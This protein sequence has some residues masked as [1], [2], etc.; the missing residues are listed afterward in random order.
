MRVSGRKECQAKKGA[1]TGTGTGAGA[2]TGAATWTG[3]KKFFF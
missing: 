3:R 2:G 1:G